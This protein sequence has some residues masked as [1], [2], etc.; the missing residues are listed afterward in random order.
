M[1]SELIPTSLVKMQSD[2]GS[3]HLVPP[4]GQALCWAWAMLWM[5]YGSVREKEASSVGATGRSHKTM[6]MTR[7]PGDADSKGS[8][9]SE[10]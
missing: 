7:G 1:G 9:T 3:N 8:R 4:E 2:Q 10:E 6:E 5:Y